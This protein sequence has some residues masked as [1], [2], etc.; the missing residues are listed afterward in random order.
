MTRTCKK[1]I[2]VLVCVL[3]V[4]GCIPDPA[5]LGYGSRDVEAAAKVKT[6]ASIKTGKKITINGLVYK[7][8]KLSKNKSTV[9]LTGLS[10]AAKKKTT[11]LKVPAYVKIKVK[12][13][14]NKGTYKYK[15][16]SIAKK[17]LKGNK[18]I[19]RVSIG[20]NVTV[21][22]QSAFEGCTS[23]TK[24]TI[25]KKSKLSTVKSRAFYNCKK[26][27]TINF[28]A[29][30]K[31]KSVPA[32]AFKNTKVKKLPGQKKTESTTAKTETKKDITQYSYEVIPMLKPFNEFFYIKTNN[33]DPDSFRF[34]DKSSKYS[35]EA[36]IVP[37]DSAYADV[38]YEKAAVK[39]VKGGY[40]GYSGNTDGGKL[41]L[42]E[43]KEAVVNGYWQT[44]YKDTSVT[45]TLPEL[46]DECDYLIK[47]YAGSG[48]FFDKMDAVQSGFSSI[49]LYSGVYILGKQKKSTDEPYYGLSTSPHADQDFYIQDPYYRED[50]K[51]MLISSLYPFR[52]DSIGFPSMMSS[53]AKRL[54][55]GASVKWDSYYHYE[56][57]V[58]YNGT[59]KTYGGAGSGGGQGIKENMVSNWFKFDNSTD[60][61]YKKASL[62]TISQK[63]NAYGKLNV[64]ED[65]KDLQE[66][67]WA[68]VRKSVGNGSYVR[69]VLINSIFGGGGTGYTYLY[70]DGGSYI[71]YFSDAWYDGRYFND[72]EYF[73]RGITFADAPEADIVIKNPVIHFPDDGK[74]WKYNGT[75]IGELPEYDAASGTWNG[76]V[77]YRYQKDQ[78]RW[79]ADF[80]YSLYY[81]DDE[82]YQYHYA[83]ESPEMLEALS[84]TKDQVTAMKVDR[85]AN[86][87]P[88]SYK[89]FD[90]KSAPGTKGG[91]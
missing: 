86:T 82:G 80:N 75:N 30:K 6:V 15:V 76:Y 52:Y 90:M 58:T 45:V 59:T 28:S 27:K 67:T 10:K 60:D 66:L 87:D 35:K 5:G 24:V 78:Q 61:Y 26:L 14:K 68:D 9:Q 8:T 37:D 38:K 71:G 55:S 77:R 1:L 46:V 65:K 69:L 74:Q 40:I 88:S 39:R 48:S 31:L 54:N 51:Y 41:V 50:S 64:P 49:C 4:L 21:I 32:N 84:L 3:M 13:G 85:N 22:G 12:K 89:I 43:E 23:L 73:S 57:Q 83:D 63:I 81:Y 56:V 91:A 17:A 62:K 42:Q 44:V 72:H 2:L 7:I 53:V 33:P 79:L 47:N 20:A 34:A 70:D 18:K 25:A 16:T 36:T 11:A 29:A 19:K